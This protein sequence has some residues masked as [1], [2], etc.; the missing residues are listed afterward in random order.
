MHRTKT[1]SPSFFSERVVNGENYK[2]MVC[3]YAMPEMLHL[4]YF[5]TFNEMVLLQIG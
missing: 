1:I 4:P 3:Y 2:E 5:Q